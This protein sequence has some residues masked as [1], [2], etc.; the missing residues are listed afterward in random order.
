MKKLKYKPS[1]VQ[2][3]RAKHAAEGV[4]L[5]DVTH[6]CE[7]KLGDSGWCNDINEPQESIYH[8]QIYYRG[9]VIVTVGQD[10]MCVI[11]DER[12]VIFGTKK[13]EGDLTNDFI[14]FYKV[15]R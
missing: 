4:T 10:G 6:L 1:R 11:D 5:I 14:I 15:H 2:L 8:I 13:W 3:F 12:F 7:L 9:D